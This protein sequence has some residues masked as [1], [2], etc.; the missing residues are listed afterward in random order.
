MNDAIDKIL[1]YEYDSI[2]LELLLADGN[3]FKI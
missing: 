1:I 3:G 2:I